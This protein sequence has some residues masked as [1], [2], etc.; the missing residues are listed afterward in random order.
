MINIAK[1]DIGEEEKKAVLEVLDSGI[2]AQG[3]KVKEFEERFAEYIGVDYAVATTSGTTALH[4]ALMAHGIDRGE[5]IT[6]PFTFIASA[7]S[8]LYAGAKPVFADINEDFNISPRRIR[9]KIN[10]DTKG[11]MPVHLYGLPCD[12]DE[13]MEI[14]NEK[15]LPVIE[16][17]CQSHGAQFKGKNVGSFGTGV[18]S[19]YPTKNM[20]TSEGGILTTND[21]EIADRAR[22]IR[23]HGSKVRYHH[24]VLGYNYRM[25]DI[26]AAI[27]LVQLK[28]IESYNKKRIENAKK[29]T[30]G[31][32]DIPGIITPGAG[33]NKRHVY[34][35]YTIRITSEFP[36]SR[37]ETINYLNENGIGCGIYYPIPI[38]EQSYYREL[39]YVDKLEVSERLAKEVISLPVHPLLEEEEIEKIIQVFKGV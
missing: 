5:V 17:A 29:L 30:E 28:K 4:L 27:G 32:K 19:F 8:I 14:A 3:P 37:D 20:T 36:K 12:M 33:K 38:H 2:I 34:H 39:G 10:S 7:N 6:T 31:L 9:E 25:T 1:P 16:D 35:Q 15:G 23:E 26:A 24:D 11:I 22:L 21:K 18:F 13:I